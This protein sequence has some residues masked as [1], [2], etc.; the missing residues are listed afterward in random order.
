MAKKDISMIIKIRP[1]QQRQNIEISV[2]NAL[3]H[4][5]QELDKVRREKI[6]HLYQI[7]SD[8]QRFRAITES[9]ATLADISNEITKRKKK[10]LKLRPEEAVSL[11]EDLYR[12]VEQLIVGHVRDYQAALARRI[13]V[14]AIDELCS[15]ERRI[16]EIFKLPEDLNQEEKESTSSVPLRNGDPETPLE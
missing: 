14:H 4:L 2:S 6:R 15:T 12:K 9:I 7:A 10:A 11:L 8:P 16:V 5:I 3:E 13:L 1:F